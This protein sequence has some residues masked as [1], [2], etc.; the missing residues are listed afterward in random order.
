MLVIT[1]NSLHNNFKIITALFLYSGDKDLVEIQQIL[2]F[3]KSTNLAKCITSQIADM[4]MMT[5]KNQ[6]NRQSQI[7]SNEE[8]FH[9][10]M[11]EYY[12]KDCCSK[13]KRKF[14]E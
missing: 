5:K 3:I 4:A 8:C 12:I 11:K 2:T 10:G 9:C 13:P 14:S 7:K 6:S 1:L